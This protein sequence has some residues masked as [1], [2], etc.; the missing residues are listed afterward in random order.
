MSRVE[1]G[2]LPQTEYES[3]YAK[4]P[5]LTVELVIVSPRGVLLS[6]RQDGPCSGL[7]NLPGGT[8]RYGEPLI[9]AVERIARDELALEV[10]VQDLL[11]YIEYPSHL[12]Q[13]I[14]W[15]V[16]IAFRCHLRAPSQDLGD[17]ESEHI[18]WFTELPT[19]IH[20]EQ[21]DFLRSRDL[22]G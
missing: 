9:D 5:R 16:G 8:V 22:A 13:Q 6:L 17:V 7:W 21:R 19:A 18:G 14:D 3:I 10:S 15:P 20:D 4:V 12:A 1:R 11:G 2:P